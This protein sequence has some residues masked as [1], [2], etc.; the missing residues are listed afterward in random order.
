M[1]NSYRILFVCMGNICRSPA[2]ETLMK[3][4]IADAGLSN[5]ITI[6]SC[7]T[8]N[9]HAGSPPDQR[10]I[11]A[12]SRRNIHMTGTAR[13]FTPMDFENFD[14]I[15]PMDNDNLQDIL[16]QAHDKT[17]KEKVTPMA[18]FI[19]QFKVNAIPDPYYGGENGFDH[20]LDLLED[21]CTNLLEYIRPHLP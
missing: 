8:I 6:D 3:K 1:A 9:Y 11:N 21:G 17:H 2:A 19:K 16:A 14:L 18:T 7:G 5:T 4:T 13:A 20:V 15:V 12:A 10:M